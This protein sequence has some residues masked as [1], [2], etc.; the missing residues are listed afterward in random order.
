MKVLVVRPSQNPSVE[1]I[2]EE[3]EDMQQVVGGYI[4]EVMPWED[5][6]AL[7]CNEEGKTLGL[8]SNRV[9]SG[10]DGQMLDIIAG[11]FFLCYAP[12]K[13]EKYLSLPEHLI[14]KYHRKFTR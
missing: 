9:I 10:E 12:A 2:G 1:E 6:V 13:S 7:V 14:E 4:E 3:L 11:T 5:D 8:P